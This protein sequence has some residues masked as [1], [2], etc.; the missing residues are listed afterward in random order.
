M[1]QSY[2][3]TGCAEGVQGRPTA[4]FKQHVTFLI[5]FKRQEQPIELEGCKKQKLVISP[6]KT[7]ET[8]VY[9]AA[10]KAFHAI[11]E[12][13]DGWPLKG[14]HSHCADDSYVPRSVNNIRDRNGSKAANQNR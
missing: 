13:E 10:S 11:L 5:G 4:C 14:R 7:A 9:V 2:N 1:I 8:L 6:L 12:L 3:S